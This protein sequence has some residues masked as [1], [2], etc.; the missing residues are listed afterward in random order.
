MKK[1]HLIVILFFF[2]SNL[3]AEDVASGGN[4]DDIKRNRISLHLGT[5]GL[6]ALNYEFLVPNVDNKLAAFINFSYAPYS[7]DDLNYATGPGVNGG[8]NKANFSISSLLIG[9]GAKYYF[10]EEQE[11]LFAA[12]EFNYQSINI[13]AD[14]VNYFADN[15]V[16]YYDQSTGNSVDIKFSDAKIEMSIPMPQFT[17]KLGYTIVSSGGFK[18]DVEAGWNFV[19]LDD[20]LPLK[21]S[22]ESNSNFTFNGKK[23]TEGERFTTEPSLSFRDENFNEYKLSGYLAFA[24]KFGWAF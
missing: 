13:E 17:P 14:G 3:T 18:F 12:L 23:T 15:N 4:S 21:I 8:E 24:L 7:L 2:V 19:F 9:I 22:A 1:Y 6:S 20:E 5:P 16:S 11:G 10:L